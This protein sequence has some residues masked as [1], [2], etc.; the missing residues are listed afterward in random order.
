MADVALAFSDTWVARFGT[1][2]DMSSVRGPQFT[3]ELC[4]DVAR[5]LGVQLYHSTAFHPQA[6]R[7]CQH[8]HRSLKSA[9]RA[10]LTDDRW[11]ERLPWVLLGLRTVPKEDLQTSSAELVYGQALR[12]PGDFIPDS[13]RPWSPFAE[14]SALL[15]RINTF[16][17]VP[18]SQHGLT[19]AWMAKDLSAAE[20]VFIHHYALFHPQYPWLKCP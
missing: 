3:S 14:R 2:S 7:L 13:T 17:P 15:D 18:T 4:A 6:N 16:K 1:P 9:L 8:F 12:V 20:F 5:I 10:S 11:S 19:V